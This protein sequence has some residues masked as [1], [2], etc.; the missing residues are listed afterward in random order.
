MPIF[1]FNFGGNSFVIKKAISDTVPDVQIKNCFL[2]VFCI[3]DLIDNNSNGAKWFDAE[4]ELKVHVN[5]L[6]GIHYD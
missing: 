6:C 3:I 4:D 2:P 5:L 1:P